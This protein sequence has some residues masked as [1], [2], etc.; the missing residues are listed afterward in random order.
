[1]SRAMAGKAARISLSLPISR[2]TADGRADDVTAFLDRYR[3]PN[4]ATT[5]IWDS[6]LRTL[7]LFRPRPNPRR[8]FFR[9]SS[10]RFPAAGR[11]DPP[12]A[13]PPSC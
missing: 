7:P 2:Q 4:D 8:M 11:P 10:V 5:P 3:G 12:G 6:L 9:E 13:K 1:M